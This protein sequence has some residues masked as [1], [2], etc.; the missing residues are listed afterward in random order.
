MSVNEFEKLNKQDSKLRIF[1]RVGWN[2]E[3]R[4]DE[5]PQTRDNKFASA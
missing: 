5:L 1:S 2:A 4:N 3:R